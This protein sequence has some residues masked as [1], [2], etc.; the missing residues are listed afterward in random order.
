MC[1]STS[2]PSLLLIGLLAAGMFIVA[3]EDKTPDAPAPK[4]QEKAS[5]ASASPGAKAPAAAPA[6]PKAE[7]AGVALPAN[8]P[9]SVTVL[10]KYAELK[11]VIMAPD[12]FEEYGQFVDMGFLA[13][14]PTKGAD[15]LVDAFWVYAMPN[16]YVWSAVVEAKLEAPKGADA[17]G[18]YRKL[19]KVIHAI[20]DKARRGG[21]YDGG[22]ERKPEY[23]G[24]RDIPAGYWVYLAPTWYVWEEIHPLPLKAPEA[25]RMDGK[26]DRLLR[27]IPAP[28]EAAKH[29]SLDGGRRETKSYK[30]VIDIPPGYWVYAAPNWYVWG[31]SN[32][33]EPP[34]R[35]PK[36]KTSAAGTPKRRAPKRGLVPTPKKP[37]DVKGK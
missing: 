35:T 13:T 4:G 31:V 30:G 25:A 21:F 16:W 32:V 19:L 18:K 17:S 15:E 27:V 36:P 29:A 8:A 28:D 9:K 7:P 2:A 34:P 10:G 5:A 12:D 14:P 6:E 33:A 37:G 24:V 22:F 11:R 23:K 20:D 26:Y 1:S 3:C